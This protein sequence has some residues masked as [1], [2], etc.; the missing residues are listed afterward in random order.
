M[1]AVSAGE[2][3]AFFALLD[4]VVDRPEGATKQRYK[5][6]GAMSD[7][8]RPSPY[9]GRPPIHKYVIYR[10]S[11]TLG[12]RFRGM[13]L[14]IQIREE[15]S[16]PSSVTTIMMEQE[17]AQLTV[18]HFWYTPT[19][20]RYRAKNV[21]IPVLGFCNPNQ[22]QGKYLYEAEGD[23]DAA[24]RERCMS[25]AANRFRARARVEARAQ[26]PPPI[27]PLPRSIPPFQ[28]LPPLYEM[29]QPTAPATPSLSRP[30]PIVIPQRNPLIPSAAP[31]ARTR[32][33]TP[34]SPPQGWVAER[35]ALL[36]S[37]HGARG[38]A[39]PPAP[40]APR[41][42]LEILKQDAIS[43]GDSCPISFTP[44]AECGSITITSCFHLFETEA[45]Q[46]WLG[47]NRLCPTCKQLVRTDARV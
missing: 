12:E 19:Y 2:L 3:P 44:F 33:P 45:L 29:V 6:L 14:E 25:Q 41:H 38:G 34:P 15:L 22:I 18:D 21:M 1:A 13:K 11:V 26:A 47:T 32:A 10:P 35:A 43:K 27:E 30:P 4:D 42:V 46:T 7:G 31:P 5:I 20:I 23:T 9:R 28:A 37:Q 8:T 17:N 40:V 36:A 16:V 24:C 39:P